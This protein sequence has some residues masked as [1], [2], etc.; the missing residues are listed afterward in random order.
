MSN[1]VVYTTTQWGAPE[2]H[3]GASVLLT[4]TLVS[5]PDTSLGVK[6]VILNTAKS[7]QEQCSLVGAGR[8]ANKQ[9]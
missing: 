9:T 6:E 5:V 7:L 8:E 1:M 3:R 2:F 4:C